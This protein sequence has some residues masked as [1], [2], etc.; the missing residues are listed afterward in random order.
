MSLQDFFFIYLTFNLRLS[1]NTDCLNGSFNLVAQYGFL[2]HLFPLVHALL[3]NAK[4]GLFPFRLVT[5]LEAPD[6]MRLQFWWQD[7]NFYVVSTASRTDVYRGRQL[8]CQESILEYFVGERSWEERLV[9]DDF[10]SRLFPSSVKTPHKWWY[11]HP[12]TYMCFCLHVYIVWSGHPCYRLPVFSALSWIR[13]LFSFAGPWL[14]PSWPGFVFNPVLK[15]EWWV[16]ACLFHFCQWLDHISEN[17]VT[18]SSAV[19]KREE[20][21]FLCSLLVGTFEE[22]VWFLFWWKQPVRAKQTF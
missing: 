8:L 9:W 5:F 16:V 19:G 4:I 1:I 3:I 11:V 14:F 10:M 2:A 20:I 21:C 6:C 13:E 17:E 12:N 22:E 7:E 18:V 15:S